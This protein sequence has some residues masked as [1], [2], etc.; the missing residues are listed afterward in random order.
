MRQQE[1]QLVRRTLIVATCFCCAAAILLRVSTISAQLLP[2]RESRLFPI[3]EGWASNQI[4]AVIFR[5]NSIT[6]HGRTQYVAFYDADARVVLAKRI[7]GS[8]RWQIRRTAL[9]GKVED[10]HNSISIAVDGDGF[11]HMAWN[12]HNSSLQYCR[13]ASPGSLELEAARPMI[14]NNETRVTYP[15]FY[16]SPGGNLLFLYRD[17]VSGGGNLILN[18]YA[19]KTRVWSRVQDNLI[20]GESKRNAYWQMAV[21]VK[22]AIHLSWVWRENP[23]VATNHDMCYAKSTDGGKSWRKSS[24]ERYHANYG[25]NCG[26]RM[27]DSAGQ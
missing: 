6:T 19:V 8:N 2:A 11:L 13:S 15:E 9:Q 24:G 21:D 12:H 26:I 10:A 22:G 3:A 16:S 23:D 25:K 27:A 17:G 20:D 5:R 14:G 18:Q 4:N 7:L 1:K